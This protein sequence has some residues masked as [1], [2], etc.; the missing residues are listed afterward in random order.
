M[1]GENLAIIAV[2]LGVIVSAYTIRNNIKKDQ[3]ERTQ[4]RKNH[5]RR[6]ENVEQRIRKLEEAIRLIQ[7]DHSLLKEDTKVLIAMQEQIST[8]FKSTERVENKIDLL[9]ET[10]LQKKGER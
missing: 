6:H 10:M 2:M 8:L 4:E 3:H 9:V 7:L 5:E 1:I